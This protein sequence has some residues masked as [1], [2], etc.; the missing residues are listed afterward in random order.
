MN[1]VSVIIPI[2]NR[3]LLVDETIR[4]VYAQTHRPI[5]LII[6]DDNS[7]EPYKLK[8]SSE[9]DFSFIIFRHENNKG[10]GASRETGRQAA[11]GDYIAYLDS[12][13]LWHPDKL[14]KQ[15]QKLQLHPETGMCYCQTSL[16]SEL[17]LTDDEPIRENCDEK[18]ENFLPIILENRPW[19]T[20]A[21]LWTREATER[22]GP[23]SENWHYEDVEFDSRAGCKDIKIS[24]VP[25]VLCYYRLNDENGSLSNSR[26]RFS[27]NQ[28][29]KSVLNITKNIQSCGKLDDDEIQ[30][31]LI[32][33][34]FKTGFTSLN[35]HDRIS[36]FKLFF[37]ISSISTDF[38]K[39][40]IF[41]LT[42]FFS[43]I[44]PVNIMNRLK[45]RLKSCI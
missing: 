43:L 42:A 12:D 34:L 35:Y 23:W 5:E 15:V 33:R 32:K 11:T 29:S 6:V 36:A 30:A 45:Y 19:C 40:I 28:L 37:Q 41:L 24:Y 20:S 21:C 9:V 13:D 7:D 14:E 16:F 2:Y 27:I 18:F 4:S 1:L 25:E 10:P 31:S 39:K 26:S 8:I 22:I 17:P 38:G 44:F 3:F